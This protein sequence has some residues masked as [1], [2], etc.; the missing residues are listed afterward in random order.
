MGICL[1]QGASGTADKKDNGAEIRV[2]PAVE[3]ACSMQ[4]Y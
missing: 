4:I 1:C 2:Q 3:S